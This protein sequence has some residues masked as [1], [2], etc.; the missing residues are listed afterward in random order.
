MAPIASIPAS[1]HKKNKQSSRKWK[2]KMVNERKEISQFD[3][4]SY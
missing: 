4:C 1:V 2:G 3:D